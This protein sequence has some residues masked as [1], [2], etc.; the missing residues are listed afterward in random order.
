MKESGK[1]YHLPCS[2]IIYNQNIDIKTTRIA[3]ALSRKF[4]NAVV[5]NK[6]RRQIKEAVRKMI[7]E[8]DPIFY[9]ILFIPKKA[10][11]G[12]NYTELLSQIQRLFVFLRHNDSTEG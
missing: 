5:R 12:I 1:K 8:S 6:V 3:F 10:M 11:I 9:D 4:G 7:K 2:T